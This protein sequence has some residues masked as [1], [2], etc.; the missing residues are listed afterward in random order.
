[1]LSRCSI[2]WCPLSEFFLSVL[3]DCSFT[4]I[5]RFS[6][7]E[8][9]SVGIFSV[10]PLGSLLENEVAIA[11]RLRVSVFISQADMWFVRVVGRPNY[12]IFFQTSLWEM[13]S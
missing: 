5:S 4:S 9:L 12:T 11:E 3:P 7:D 2:S 10:P 13:F 6:R 1:M 8:P